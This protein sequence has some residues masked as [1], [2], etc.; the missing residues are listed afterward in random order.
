[1]KCC[2]EKK[3]KSVLHN[4]ERELSTAT[5]GGQENGEGP[6]ALMFTR[7]DAGLDEGAAKGME[8]QIVPNQPLIKLHPYGWK[9]MYLWKRKQVLYCLTMVGENA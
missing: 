7:E 2:V 4:V 5:P 1:M 3:R 8:K 6:P 9:E